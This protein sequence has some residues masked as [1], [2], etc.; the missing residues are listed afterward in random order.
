MSLRNQGIDQQA[1]IVAEAMDQSA[2]SALKTLAPGNMG[3]FY[4]FCVCVCVCIHVCVYACM[5]VC[6]YVNMVRLWINLRLA[7]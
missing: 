5:Y 6:T 3:R 4:V 2:V 7:R 1:F